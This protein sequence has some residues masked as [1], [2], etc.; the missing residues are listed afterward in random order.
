MADAVSYD[1][2]TTAPTRDVAPLLADAT[3]V[4]GDKIT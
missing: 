1:I 4:L 3:M 2:P